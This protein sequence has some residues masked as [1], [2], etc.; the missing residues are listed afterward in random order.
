M[1][2]L[3]LLGEKNY[4]AHALAGKWAFSIEDYNKC[5]KEFEAAH[6]LRG[7]IKPRPKADPALYY[8]WGLVYYING[9]SKTAIRLIRRAVRLAPDYD[10]F[11]EKLDE[12]IKA[13]GAADTQ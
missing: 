3:S 1:P 5:A 9:K 4:E 8:L 11:R 10:L 13:Q 12:I 6:K 7:A 2:K